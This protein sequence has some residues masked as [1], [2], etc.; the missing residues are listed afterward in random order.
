MEK[1]FDV[2]DNV[3]VVSS[4]YDGIVKGDVGTVVWGGGVTTGVEFEGAEYI[5]FSSELSLYNFDPTYYP[6]IV[7]PEP[8]GRIKPEIKVG[9]IVSVLGDD[10]INEFRS[11]EAVMNVFR[12][13]KVQHGSYLVEFLNESG[14]YSFAQ[15]T[16]EDEL[17]VLV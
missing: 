14:T 17:L 4:P 7:E 12:V 5:F 16:D 15:L 8:V 6:E 9:D 3:L 1:M 11:G 10:S 13:I 2:G